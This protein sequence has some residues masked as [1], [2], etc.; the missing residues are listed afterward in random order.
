VVGVFARPE[1]RPAEAGDETGVL[2]ARD[3][4]DRR[5]DAALQ[6]RPVEAE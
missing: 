2:L 1:E 4:V 6:K 3:A 5:H